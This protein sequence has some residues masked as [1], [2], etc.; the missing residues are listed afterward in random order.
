MHRISV[1]ENETAPVISIFKQ[2]NQYIKVN[3]RRSKDAITDE[4]NQLLRPYITWSL[5][6]SCKLFPGGFDNECTTK[7]ATW[8]IRVL[9][10]YRM[11]WIIT[12]VTKLVSNQQ[13]QVKS[14]S[15]QLVPK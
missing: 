2:K 15:V 9:Q 4:L 10:Y 13:K 12:L 14:E 11:G 3:S 8:W 6:K 1:F 5:I 7:I